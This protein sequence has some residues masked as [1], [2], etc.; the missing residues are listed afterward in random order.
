MEKERNIKEFARKITREITKMTEGRRLTM[1]EKTTGKMEGRKMRQEEEK[2]LKKIAE[3]VGSLFEE[4]FPLSYQLVVEKKHVK[5]ILLL[6]ALYRSTVPVK[7]GNEGLDG[8][9]E[10][11]KK[12]YEEL[13][14]PD[15]I[16]H[17]Y[18]SEKEE[19]GENAE[20][21]LQE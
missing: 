16:I 21:G 11:V 15:L 20:G 1:S 7:E 12:E 2:L 17:Y 6:Y 14:L 18:S 10:E 3:L 5:I 8:F 9:F 4:D 13:I 19:N